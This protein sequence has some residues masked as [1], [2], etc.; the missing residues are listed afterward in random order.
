MSIPELIEIKDIEGLTK[1]ELGIKEDTIKTDED[2]SDKGETEKGIEFDKEKFETKMNF[3]TKIIKE[4][5]GGV[6]V[7]S[8]INPI[9][10][11]EQWKTSSNLSKGEIGMLSS[12]LAFTRTSPEECEPVLDFCVDYCLL[13]LSEE[14]FAIDKAIDLG[15][16][17]TEKT[18][19]S[20]M[21]YSPEKP[22]EGMKKK[23][24]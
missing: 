22:Q 14:G 16:A 11:P 7:S 3:V 8:R 4:L 20:S 15:K 6:D 10:K 13:K 1:E 5:S 24:K 17:L 19:S 2:K 9:L 18:T 12:L 21:Y 23:E